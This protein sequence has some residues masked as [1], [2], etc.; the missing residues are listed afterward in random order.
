LKEIPH[1]PR[2][3]FPDRKGPT[4]M[5]RSLN[6]DKPHQAPQ[7]EISE[8]WAKRRSYK[9]PEIVKITSPTKS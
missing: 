9:L 1:E 6:E 7:D 4:L 5:F 8:H 2:T 3:E